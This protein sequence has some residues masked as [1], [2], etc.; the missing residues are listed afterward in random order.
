[1][2]EREFI[3]YYGEYSLYHWME[4]VLK[5]EIILPDFQRYFVWNPEQVIKLI[6]SLDEG[7]F[8]PPIILAADSEHNVNYILDGQQRL[9]AI[10]LAYFGVFPAKFKTIEDIMEND[11][12]TNDFG[13][14]A[15]EYS[16]KKPINWDLGK[17]QKDFK[18]ECDSD[19]NKLRDF[20]QKDEKYLSIP[21]SI[22]EKEYRKINRKIIEKYQQKVIDTDFLKNKFLGFSYIKAVKKDPEKEKRLFA[23]IFRTINISSVRLLPEE[24]RASLYWL[25]PQNVKNKFF[26]PDFLQNVRVSNNKLDF[27]RLLAYVSDAYSRLTGTTNNRNCCDEVAMG[28]SYSSRY[29][30]YI[31]LY[32]NSVIENEDDERFGKFSEIFPSLEED[33]KKLEETYKNIFGNKKHYKNLVE[34][35]YYFFG[36]LFWQFFNK[37]NII[38]D[39]NLVS[40]LEEKAQELHTYYDGKNTGRLGAIRRR[41]R[42]SIE[43]YEK[44]LE[45]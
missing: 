37:K 8:V 31:E 11:M 40:E 14:S 41:L 32:V 35:D 26:R 44:Y 5:S 36:L 19:S 17:I 15:I 43:I 4:M 10:L 3:T 21:E 9:S 23:R 1:M 2:S 27:A 30:E 22:K 28:Y 7:S 39:I 38:K 29:E 24:S 18:D 33:L 6:Q 13:D 34:A 45:D 12:N 16:D 20:I 25:A 42:E